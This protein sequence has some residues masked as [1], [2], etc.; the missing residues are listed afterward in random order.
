MALEDAVVLAELLGTDM[1][2]EQALTALGKRRW[3]RCKLVQDVSHQILLNEMSV[4]AESLPDAIKRMRA[5]LP[6]QSAQ[7]A[8][9]LNQPA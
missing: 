9:V 3:P 2:V 7:V 8:A 6:G 4:T 5:D 1:P